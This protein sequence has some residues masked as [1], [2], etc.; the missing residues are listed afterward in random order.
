MQIK[1][2]ETKNDLKEFILLPWQIYKSDPYWVPPLISEVYSILDPQ[3]NPFWEHAQQKLFLAKENG[4]V[5]GRI[6]GIIDQNHIDLHKEQVGFFG[7]F[8]VFK[9]HK[10]A[11]LLL[12]QVQEWLK[13]KGM[14]AMRGPLNPSMNDECGFLLEGFD[15]S[16]TIMM[17]YNPPYYLEFMEKFGL[18]KA[19]DLFALI[20]HVSEGMPERLIKLAEWSKEREG[21]TIRK[22]DMKNLKREA[23]IMKE[24]YN[25]AWEK[26]WGFV[27][28][29]DEEI[30][31]MLEKLKPLV[32]PELVLIAEAKGIP[33]G[34]SITLPDF[35]Q[36]LKKL[37]G[38]M[39]PI[40]IIKFLYYK[41]KISGCRSLVGGILKEYRNTGIITALSYETEKAARKL[42]YEWCEMSWNLEDNDLINRFEL[43]MGA[44]IYK[45]YRIYETKI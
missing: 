45:K 17:P 38:R 11:E 30:D 31:L 1:F 33:I 15:S 8:E 36:V 2:V 42:G 23:Q 41:N 34:L 14:T 6:A 37:N 27:P 40:E 12:S 21:I 13:E 19:K 39:G 29:T 16:P 5:V 9:D 20:K 18:K 10:I 26:N 22:L 3:K 28:M 44:K 43:A 7:F 32:V 4:K 25:S 35:N 24:L